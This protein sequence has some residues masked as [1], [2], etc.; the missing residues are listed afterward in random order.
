MLFA[1]HAAMGSDAHAVARDHCSTVFLEAYRDHVGRMR[2]KLKTLGA[3]SRCSWK[4]VNTLLTKAGSAAKIPALQRADGI[5]VMDP[6][7][8]ANE[9]AE[10]FRAKARLPPQVTN[11][12]TALPE[13]PAGPQHSG[14]LRIRTRTVYKI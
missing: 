8:R 1:K 5:W 10:T 12:Y 6:E 7:E 13:H 2:D 9:L 4:I 11:I 3:G 14:F